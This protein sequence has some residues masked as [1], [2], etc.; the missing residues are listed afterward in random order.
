MKA[1]TKKFVLAKEDNKYKKLTDLQ[2]NVFNNFLEGVTN[3]LKDEKYNDDSHYRLEYKNGNIYYF[4]NYKYIYPI[5]IKSVDFVEAIN[6][7]LDLNEICSAYTYDN[8]YFVLDHFLSNNALTRTIYEL[9]KEI[10]NN[11]NLLSEFLLAASFLRYDVLN[12]LTKVDEVTI[13]REGKVIYIFNERRELIHSEIANSE[14]FFKNS[15]L[16]L[17]NY[18]SESPNTPKSLK[19]E[20]KI[21]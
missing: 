10:Q 1:F 2:I 16:V 21:I 3:I 20:N 8:N 17:S 18:M 9:P 11:P 5:V 13:N 6:N 12:K 19:L 15:L 4:D 14:S 7:N